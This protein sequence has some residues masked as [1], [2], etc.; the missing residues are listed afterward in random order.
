MIKI[1]LL[2]Y[3]VFVNINESIKYFIDEYIRM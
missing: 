2:I 1:V 3:Y